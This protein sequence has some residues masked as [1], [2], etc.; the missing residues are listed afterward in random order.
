[1]GV[2]L[3]QFRNLPNKE[4]VIACEMQV[5]R[6]KLLSGHVTHKVSIL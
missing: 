2:N 6:A 5:C 1:M 3:G 4:R